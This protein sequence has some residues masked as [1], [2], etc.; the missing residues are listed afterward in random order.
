MDNTGTC[1]KWRH[2]VQAYMDRVFP[3]A[4]Y[5][6]ALFF[7]VYA[8]YR[9]KVAVPTRWGSLLYLCAIGYFCVALVLLGALFQKKSLPFRML[10]WNLIWIALTRL[11]FGG[12]AVLRESNF[13][14]WS[15]VY[16]A[17]FASL[18]Y[19]RPKPRKLL[20]QLVT[21]EFSAV[22]AVWAVL[23]I[24][25]ALVGHSVA[26][27]SG[28]HM[29]NEGPLVFVQYFY[30]HRNITASYFVFAIGLLLIQ[31]A[32]CRKK[33]MWI[34]AALLVPLWYLSVAL[35][36]SRSCYLA[37]AAL[38]M[39]TLYAFLREKLDWEKRWIGKGLGLCALLVCVVLVYATFNLSSS[40]LMAATSG[41]RA[42]AAAETAGNASAGAQEETILT[43]ADDR[44]TLED[45]AT[46]SLRVGIWKAGIE[47]VRENPR[48]ALL[49]ELGGPGMKLVQLKE[50]VL[51]PSHMHNMLFEQMILSGIPG[52][53]LY[54]VFLLALLWRIICC[55]LG[56][57]RETA[58]SV[59]AALLASLMIFG[60]F[61]PLFGPFLTVSSTLFC[62]TA[63][64]FTQ[65]FGEACGRSRRP[66]PAE[67]A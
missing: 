56:R 7:P 9:Q 27:V 3:A 48:I 57:R 40:G 55:Y 47:V 4:A 28:I 29:G 2:L 51:Q 44:S 45:A 64:A 59:M 50:S 49:G 17:A 19:L 65:G 10:L 11:L 46:M 25:T 31:C 22:M 66:V 60:M 5:Y 41:L 18:A 53:L 62:L 12:L 35:L 23:G 38:L 63:G 30:M 20:L 14:R 61:E 21:V 15:A 37:C 39:M 26:G 42:S 32:V 8:V 33:W 43:V 54:T 1:G 36:H 52:M 58:L 34:P 16:T 67:K 24:A 6:A 13:L